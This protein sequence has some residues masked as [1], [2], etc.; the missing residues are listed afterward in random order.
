MVKVLRRNSAALVTL[1]RVDQFEFALT[2]NTTE[3][4]LAVCLATVSKHET[5]L[6]LLS[7]KS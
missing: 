6:T 3:L 2:Q 7:G 1:E 5:F 4:V